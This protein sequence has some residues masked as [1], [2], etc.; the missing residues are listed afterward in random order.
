[1]YRVDTDAG[2]G[3]RGLITVGRLRTR[4][5][6][7]ALGA[8]LAGLAVPTHTAAAAPSPEVTATARCATTL[9]VVAHQDDDLLFVNPDISADIAG[10]RCMVTVFTTAGDAGRG[11]AYW[12]GREKGAMAAYA[13]MAGVAD[14]WVTDTVVVA[15][16]KLTKVSL[17]NRPISLIFLR[18]PDGHGYAEHDFEAM[19][20]LYKGTLGTIHAIDGSAAYTRQSLT[21]TLTALMDTFL[22]DTIRTLD[23]VGAYGDGDHG[24][25]HSAAY[26]TLAAHRDYTAP[27]R[28]YGYQGYAAVKRPVNLSGPVRDTK[29]RHFIAYG[30]HDH[31]VC[32]TRAACFANA[33]YAPRFSHRYLTG[34]QV[35]GVGNVAPAAQVTASSDSTPGHRP[36][37]DAVDDAVPGFTA[38]P[39]S[40]WATRGGRAGS[41][42][43]LG[44]ASPQHLTRVVLHD[45]PNARDRVTAGLLT[46]SDG[47]TVP[48]GALPDNG[49]AQ[50]I[51]FAP[52]TV[53]GVRLTVT[54]VSGTTRNVGLA[55]FQAYTR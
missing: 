10:R 36:A 26:F 1:M 40:E 27:H 32:S 8:I 50:I 11:R 23:Y 46:F 35:G 54:K 5:A 34:A 45:R 7:A 41:W 4:T 25:H 2:P 44:W 47:S 17:V 30:K 22:P 9:S 18:L 33:V 55:E 31:H 53:T 3:K 13:S 19:H 14:T 6:F 39:N 51:R 29:M 28:I 21:G 15:G 49:E 24:D 38:A 16:S 43:N 42:I 52:R 37:E 48:V 12:R 20:N